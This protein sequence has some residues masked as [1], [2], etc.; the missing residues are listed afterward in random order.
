MKPNSGTQPQAFDIG[1]PSMSRIELALSHD[2][3]R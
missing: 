3:E 2:L 1:E